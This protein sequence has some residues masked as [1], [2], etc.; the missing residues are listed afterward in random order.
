MWHHGCSGPPLSEKHVKVRVVY[1]TVLFVTP[2]CVHAA[3]NVGVVFR[4]VVSLSRRI[5]C[6]PVT[7]GSRH[8]LPRG[9]IRR[10]QVIGSRSVP[11]VPSS[12]VRDVFIAHPSYLKDELVKHFFMDSFLDRCEL[13]ARRVPCHTS[14]Q[15]L[16]SAA[17]R[18]LLLTSARSMV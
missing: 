11:L 6:V 2:Q 5:E 3:H 7:R 8:R 13:F 14:M 12:V 4:G 17:N 15:S 10:G 9:H 18:A 1:G 16:R